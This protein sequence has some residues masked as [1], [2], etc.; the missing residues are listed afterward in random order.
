MNLML[1]LATLINEG[2]LEESPNIGA[3]AGQSNK[4]GNIIGIIFGVF[5]VRVEING[6]LISTDG[7]IIAGDVLA[8]ADAL[9]EGIAFD[10]EMV[11]AVDGLGK[12]ERR[13]RRGERCRRRRRRR[14]AVV[15]CV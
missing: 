15:H 11:G 9:G 14:R 4:Y 3:L 8:D 1:S 5:T 12:G 6:P 2:E 13:R 7:E 10:G